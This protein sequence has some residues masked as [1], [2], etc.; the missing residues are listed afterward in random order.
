MNAINPV[1]LDTNDINEAV[2]STSMLADV[3]ISVWGGERSDADAT[4]KI[5]DDN[6]ATGDVGRFIKKMLAGH[7]G[8]LKDTKSAFAAVRLKHYSLTL[9]WVSDPHATRMTGARLLPNLLFERYM[10]EM[11]AAKRA[12][13]V[14]LDK[15]IAEYP[16]LVE[17]A[18]LNLGGLAD[19]TYPTPEDVRSKFRVTFDFEP[20]P[21]GAAFRGLPDAMLA[22]LSRGLADKQNRMITTAQAAMWR[23]VRERLQHLHDRLS[24]TTDGGDPVRFKVSTIENVRELDMLL[25][26]WNIIGN[27]DVLEIHGDILDMIKDVTAERVRDNAHVREDVVKR[28]HRIIAK[29]DVWGV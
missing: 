4:S 3:T 18:K 15:F 8:S 28:A 1:S 25:P 10:Q 19:V 20:I 22:K 26:G 21:A 24:A 5:R 29:L 23:E 7:D 9:P 11:S 6:N 12:A 17:K 14:E 16:E 2:R 13:T 27:P